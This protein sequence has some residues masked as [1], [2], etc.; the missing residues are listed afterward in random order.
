MYDTDN[1]LIT[2]LAKNS[3][4]GG[5][6]VNLCNFLDES[7]IN[8]T[9]AAKLLHWHI[10]FDHKSMSR[11]QAFFCLIPFQFEMF[12]VVSICVLTL[13]TACQFAKVYQQSTKGS[14]KSA[15]VGSH[16]N[17]LRTG[18]LLSTDHFV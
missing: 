11:I 15:N 3:T 10:Y 9:L 13:C 4:S 16:T 17:Y 7:N 6:E 14:I 2:I 5:A 12:K 18:E 8:A 1:D